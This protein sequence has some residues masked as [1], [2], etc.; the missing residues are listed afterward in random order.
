[1]CYVKKLGLLI[2]FKVALTWFRLLIILTIGFTTIFYNLINLTI[3]FTY[4]CKLINQTMGSVTS[5]CK[6]II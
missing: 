1:M 5:L 6:L 2:D 3:S 4:F